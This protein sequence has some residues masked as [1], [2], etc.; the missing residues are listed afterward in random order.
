M[1]VSIKNYNIIFKM[2]NSVARKVSYVEII[3][4]NDRKKK[5]KYMI[6]VANL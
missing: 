1:L 3:R 6:F 5:E 4:E 2:V